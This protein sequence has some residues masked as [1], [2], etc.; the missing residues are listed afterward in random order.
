MAGCVVAVAEAVRAVVSAAVVCATVAARAWT[1]AVAV[2]STRL[3]WVT[4]LRCSGL[5]CWAVV[6][7]VAAVAA[8][9]IAGA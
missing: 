2:A 5:W 7:A 1:A 4:W 6:T 9:V 8:A 3:A